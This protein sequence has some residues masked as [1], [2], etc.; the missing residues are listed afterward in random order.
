MENVIHVGQVSDASLEVLY[1]NAAAF[2]FPSH[3]EGLGL[4]PAEFC[5]EGNGE[6]IVRDIPALREIYG[7][8]AH[9]FASEDQIVSML[10]A[11]AENGLMPR[12]PPPL[13][14]EKLRARLDSSAT[15]ERLWQAIVSHADS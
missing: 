9:L 13:R 8:V 11:V 3:F 12:L 15:F 7:D 4:P 5:E 14:R 1:R 6:L 10:R 2:V